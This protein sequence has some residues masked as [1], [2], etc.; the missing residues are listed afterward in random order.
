[1]RSGGVKD[2][3]GTEGGVWAGEKSKVA[4]GNGLMG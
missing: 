4:G 3:R 2:R 1:M